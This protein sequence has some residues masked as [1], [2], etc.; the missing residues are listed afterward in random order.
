MKKENN[1]L[2]NIIGTGYDVCVCELPPG[3]MDELGVGIA[4]E[5]RSLGDL[6]FEDEF[7]KKYSISKSDTKNYE[8]WKDFGNKGIYRGANL[9]ERGQL[10]IWFNR[11]RLITYQFNE[12]IN[13]GILFPLFDNQEQKLK[14]LVSD[15]SNFVIGVQE[16]GHLAKFKMKIDTFIPGAFQLHIIEIFTPEKIIRLLHKITYEGNTLKSIK[17]DTVVTGTLFNWI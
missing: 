4:Q 5:E 12:L 13:E 17:D 14:E 9:A 8:S 16:K 10:E 3:L 1:I 2:I 6:L 15:K 11:K 7:Y